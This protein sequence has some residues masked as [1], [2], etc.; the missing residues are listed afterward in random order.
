MRSEM[1]C[2]GKLVLVGQK[3]IFGPSCWEGSNLQEMGVPVLPKWSKRHP[4]HAHLNSGIPSGDAWGDAWSGWCHLSDATSVHLHFVHV[5]IPGIL[6]QPHSKNEAP[7]TLPGGLKYCFLHCAAVRPPSSPSGKSHYERLDVRSLALPFDSRRLLFYGSPT[8]TSAMRVN[9][10]RIKGQRIPSK[11]RQIGA[12]IVG[13]AAH[14]W[15]LV[16]Q[17]QGIRLPE[18]WLP[19]EAVVRL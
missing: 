9:L 2:M 13:E 7:V 12:Q 4:D 15:V 6:I 1:L 5:S 11:E 14:H 3:V 19:R 10:P 16:G 17:F 18:L 8:H